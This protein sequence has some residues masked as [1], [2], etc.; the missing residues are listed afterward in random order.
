MG[1]DAGLRQPRACAEL[2]LRSSEFSQCR[3]ALLP[4]PCSFQS[5][6]STQSQSPPDHHLMVKDSGHEIKERTPA[7]SPSVCP[8][9][10]LP[11]GSS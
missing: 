7:L 9:D 10:P 6:V 8:A 3:S 2:V 1:P 4:A 5:L 11:P